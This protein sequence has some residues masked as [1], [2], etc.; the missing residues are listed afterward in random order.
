MQQDFNSLNKLIELG[1]DFAVRYGLQLLGA[2]VVFVIGL[3]LALWLG[4]RTTLLAERKKLD[5]T[6]ARFFGNVVK[7]IVLTAVILIT[8]G[9]FGISIAPLIALA[10]ASA[11]GA[12]LAI[13][14]PLSNYGAGLAIILSR[15]FVVGDTI[16]VKH[17]SGVVEDITLAATRLR[18]EDGEEITVPN[19]SINGEIIVNSRSHRVVE[20]RVTLEQTVDHAAAFAAIKKALSGFEGVMTGP[21]P[22]I[23]IHE[24]TAFDLVVGVRYWAPS[25]QY[26]QTRYA[27]NT[28]ILEELRSIR[29]LPR[30]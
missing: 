27:V 16:E 4:M 11:F 12:T 26:F 1:L 23:G 19:K 2:L 6:L 17:V 13:Q 8:L 20:T 14:G 18:N 3:K 7:I 24:F 22:Q 10:G 9:N 25:R 21:V 30:V 29:I 15:P 5:V 28:A